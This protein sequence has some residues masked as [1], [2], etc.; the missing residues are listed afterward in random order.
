M[1]FMHIGLEQR[2]LLCAALCMSGLYETK[3]AAIVL[4]SALPVRAKF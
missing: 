3:D 2:G 4:F 1:R